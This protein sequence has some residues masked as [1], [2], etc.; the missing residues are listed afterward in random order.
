MIVVKLEVLGRSG[1]LGYFLHI[2]L[3]QRIFGAVD[4]RQHA[5]SA[6]A[7]LIISAG[8]ETQEVDGR[9]GRILAHSDAITPTQYIAGVAFAAIDHWEGEQAEVFTQAFLVFALS[10]DGTW[11]PLAHQLHGGLALGHLGGLLVKGLG[12][13]ALGEGVEID[14]IFQFLTA[15]DKGSIGEFAGAVNHRIKSLFAAQA[16]GHIRPVKVTGPLILVA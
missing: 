6:H 15:F 4:R 5:Q 8:E 10:I 9:V 12:F 2:R 1:Q 16:N 3:R 14:Q 7:F 11:G 13:R